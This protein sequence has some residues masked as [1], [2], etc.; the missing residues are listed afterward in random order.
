MK[1]CLWNERWISVPAFHGGYIAESA[2]MP[3]EF[4]SMEVKDF[5]LKFRRHCS[6]IIKD[7]AKHMHLYELSR[8]SKV[9]EAHVMKRSILTNGSREEPNV[10]KGLTWDWI[11]ARLMSYICWNE[12]CVL[13]NDRLSIDLPYHLLSSRAYTTHERKQRQQQVVEVSVFVSGVCWKISIH[14]CNSEML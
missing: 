9:I 3:D 7:S 1:H 14:C 4:W 12:L 8:K 6:D 13:I 2:L 11:F 10:S 5:V